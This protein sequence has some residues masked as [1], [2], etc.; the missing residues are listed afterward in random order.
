MVDR[1]E[2]VAQTKQGI[3]GIKVA[4]LAPGIKMCDQITVDAEFMEAVKKN[5][6]FEEVEETFK[7]VKKKRA[8]KK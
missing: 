1:A 5:V 3:V 7:K 6:T 2:A 8:A 4:I